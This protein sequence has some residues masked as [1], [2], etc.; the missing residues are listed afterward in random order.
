MKR[1]TATLIAKRIIYEMLDDNYLDNFNISHNIYLD[2]DMIR[3][4]FNRL[5][6]RIVKYLKIDL[7][8]D[9]IEESLNQQIFDE[10]QNNA[11]YCEN[12]GNAQY[13]KNQIDMIEEL[14]VTLI[15]VCECCGYYNE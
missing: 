4:E 14:G 12:C 9:S 5:K 3:E 7:N 8:Y 1:K 15:D 13:S 11:I 6:E 10:I 2:D